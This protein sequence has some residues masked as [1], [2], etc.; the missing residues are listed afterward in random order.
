M[1][2]K[3]ISNSP[4]LTGMRR[5]DVMVRLG[6]NPCAIA[7]Q[8]TRLSDAHVIPLLG[9]P[10]PHES[11]AVVLSLVAELIHETPRHA[12]VSVL[13]SRLGIGYGVAQRALDSLAKKERARSEAGMARKPSDEMS[14]LCATVPLTVRGVK[15]SSKA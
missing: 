15:K 14:A 4:L 7:R 1:P 2:P 6:L 10:L 8:I 3:P 5:L 11:H 9:P 13:N 12:N